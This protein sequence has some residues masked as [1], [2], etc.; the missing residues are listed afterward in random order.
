MKIVQIG[1]GGENH[2]QTLSDL[3]VLSAVF[4]SDFSRS[5]E[6]GQK[7]SVN[8]YDSEEQLIASEDFD[9]AMVG[10]N[11]SIQ[12][13]TNLLYD[14]KHVFLEKSL[15]LDSVEFQ[16]LKELSEK[17]KVVLTCGFDERFNSSID[18]LRESIRQRKFGEIVTLEFY[19]Q[20]VLSDKNNG[21]I[22]DISIN[23]I[24]IANLLMGSFPVLVF[25][26]LDY[27]E[28]EKENFASIMLGYEN[29]KTVIILS[30]GIIPDRMKKLRVVCS[31][32]VLELDLNTDNITIENQ[33]SL[34]VTE[35][36]DTMK[37]HIENFI[38]AIENKTQLLLKPNDIFN[39]TKICEAALLS[40]KQGVPIYLDL[41]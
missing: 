8:Y 6:I 30:N 1:L 9:G 3:G 20:S 26:R 36:R 34:S 32:E 28:S 10:S 40:S 7:Y 23:D 39:L 41:K 31:K 12:T 4:D 19:R 2:A 15:N 11:V 35:K 5:K 17:K 21:I 14:K 38:E 24:D 37:F 33:K 22:F 29:K 27:S 18:V 16:K 13:I 25:A